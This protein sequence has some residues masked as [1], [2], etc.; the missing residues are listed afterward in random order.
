M[1]LQ[2]HIVRL[3]M[4]PTLTLSQAKDNKLMLSLILSRLIHFEVHD[5]SLQVHYTLL[6]DP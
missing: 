3:A 1:S 2:M 4:I 5:I 6:Q